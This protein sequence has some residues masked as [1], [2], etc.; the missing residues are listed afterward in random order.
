MLW[1]KSTPTFEGTVVALSVKTNTGE[2]NGQSSCCHASI[3]MDNT[4]DQANVR[5]RS[6]TLYC[7]H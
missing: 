6:G 5:C 3:I 1:T 2:K 4:V 7:T